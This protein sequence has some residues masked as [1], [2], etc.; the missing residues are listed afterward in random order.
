[1]NK[2]V[3]VLTAPFRYL[4]Y[5]LIYTYKFTISKIMPDCCIYEPTCSTYTLIAIKRFGVFKGCALG[6]KRIFRCCPK[7]KGGLDPVPDNLKSNV[8][9]VV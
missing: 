9:Y 3:R 6:A 1:V 7:Y 5:G 8:K 4:C 2:F